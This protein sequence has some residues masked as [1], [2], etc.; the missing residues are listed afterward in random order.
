LAGVLLPAT[1]IWLEATQH[2]CAQMFFDP[3]PSWWNVLLVSCAP[4]ANAAALI[5][6][7]GF[8]RPNARKLLHFNAV[9]WV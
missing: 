3:L 1:T 2:W 7:F 4:L 9:P 6:L 5:S 8:G